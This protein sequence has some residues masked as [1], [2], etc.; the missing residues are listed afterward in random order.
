MGTAAEDWERSDQPRR[1]STACREASAVEPE[2]AEAESRAKRLGW[3]AADYDGVVAPQGRHS[4]L[5]AGA[6][7]RGV[8]SQISKGYRVKSGKVKGRKVRR[9]DGAGG[10]G[11]AHFSIS[12]FQRFSAFEQFKRLQTKGAESGIKGGESD[13]RRFGEGSNPCIGPEIG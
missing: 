8:E 4:P 1:G 3:R 12:V 2:R 13:L 9:G 6:V 7:N 11:A 5:A 10:E